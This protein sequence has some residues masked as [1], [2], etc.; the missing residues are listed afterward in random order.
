[1]VAF[2]LDLNMTNANEGGVGLAGTNCGGLTVW[3]GARSPHIF[4]VLRYLTDTP[5]MGGPKI[6]FHQ[7]SYPLSATLTMTPPLAFRL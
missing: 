2:I 7:R 6:L 5:L 1:M 4:H 3:K